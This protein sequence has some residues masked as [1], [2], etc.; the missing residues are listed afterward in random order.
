MIK[1]SIRYLEKL[2]SYNMRTIR[3]YVGLYENILEN[4]IE[5]ANIKADDTVLHIGSGAIPFSAILIAQKT[6]AKVITVDN[7]RNAVKRSRKVVNKLRLSDVIE[8][9]HQD[10]TAQIAERVTV[11]LLALQTRPLAEIIKRHQTDH[12]PVR[13]IARIPEPGYRHHYDTLPDDI[14]IKQA[15][16]QD[17]KA[18]KK[19]VL[20]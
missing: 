7:D 9:R 10:G 18:F 15:I 11:V 17:M 1:T 2:L 14:N 4:E 3:Y 13:F 16:K 6:G 20:F 5:L 19:S 8:V 12:A